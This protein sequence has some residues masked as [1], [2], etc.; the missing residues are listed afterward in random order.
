MVMILYFTLYII[1]VI[2]LINVYIGS[3]EI[4][5][6]LFYMFY[7]NNN[8]I[9]LIFVLVFNILFMCSYCHASE[10]VVKWLLLLYLYK[11]IVLFL[12]TCYCNFAA[13]KNGF[14]IW[15]L[16]NMSYTIALLLTYM[17]YK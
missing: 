17:M 7:N 14:F 15:N 11:N 8:Y 2:L 6:I 1:H 10:N 12:V 13:N 4:F 9:I 16:G 3:Y 5:V